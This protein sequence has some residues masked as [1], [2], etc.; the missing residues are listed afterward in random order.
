MLCWRTSSPRR[1]PR[2]RGWGGGEG[3]GVLALAVKRAARRVV[4]HGVGA[5]PAGIQVGV[6]RR[7]RAL[8]VERAGTVRYTGWSANDASREASL[9]IVLRRGAPDASAV[10]RAVEKADH[11]ADDAVATLVDDVRGGHEG[12]VP[13]PGAVLLAAR[14]AADRDH[15]RTR[16][17]S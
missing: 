5:L 17:P 14:G 11:S 10:L 2:R 13:D 7:L 15:S 9:A 6:E 12:V 4:A 3:G 16:P 8:E 1:R